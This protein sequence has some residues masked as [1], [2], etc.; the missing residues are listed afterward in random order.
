MTFEDA[1][2]PMMALRKANAKAMREGVIFCAR[3]PIIS[4]DLV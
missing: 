2:K 4:V 1:Q 3:K